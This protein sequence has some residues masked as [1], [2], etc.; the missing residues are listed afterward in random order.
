MSSKNIKK[1]KSDNESKQVQKEEIEVKLASQHASQQ[2]SQQ[3][4]KQSKKDA[5][6]APVK[7]TKSS[8]KVKDVKE[9]DDSDDS[10]DSDDSD[11][12]QLIEEDDS[13]EEHVADD[14]D[15]DE[16]TAEKPK[17][18]KAKESYDELTK[19]VEEILSKKATLHKKRGEL[20]TEMK[21]VQRDFNE[22]ERELKKV[23]KEKD[24]RHVDDVHRAR[25]EGGKKKRSGN[26]SAGIMEAKP[27]PEPLRKFIG[28]SED[29]RM[30]LP[31]LMSAMTNK[32]VDTKQK[33]GQTAFLSK[34]T[35]KTLGLPT[36]DAPKE[37]KFTEMMA[38]L[39][40]FYPKKEKVVEVDV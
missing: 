31:K 22:C 17:E 11:E 1:S 35:L 16:E 25:K 12:E 38:F 18:K 20:E 37:I 19:H 26:V 29:T 23:L 32:L 40:S 30:T 2:A 10:S 39:A 15:S 33:Q 28:L 3:S 13:D 36:S 27:I 6:K 14:S 21:Q 24:L 8:V 7:E 4:S 5:P 34:E 9:D